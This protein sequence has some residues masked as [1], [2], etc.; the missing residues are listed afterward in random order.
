MQ[1]LLQKVYATQHQVTC[2][3]LKLVA[4]IVEAHISFAQVEELIAPGAPLW[5][6]QIAI[7]LYACEIA[8]AWEAR[9][10]CQAQLSLSMLLREWF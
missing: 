4:D 9:P 2:L 1:V 8:A 6:Q 7:L 10:A 5:L 3:I